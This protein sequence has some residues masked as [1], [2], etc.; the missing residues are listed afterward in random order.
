M[1]QLPE[2]CVDRNLGKTVPARLSVLGW[3]MH[4]I[5]EEFPNDAQDVSDAD[6]IAYG[7]NKAWVPLCK[8]GRIRGRDHEREPVERYAGVL[9]YLDNQQLLVDEMVRRIARAEAE[10]IRA[11]TRGGPALY[12]IGADAIR[13]TWP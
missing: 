3:T 8:D 9:F 4:L 5:A 10:I 11:V 7:F 13:R 6:W 2:F 12:A 1:P